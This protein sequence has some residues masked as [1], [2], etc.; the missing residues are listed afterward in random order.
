M[1]NC[2]D[3]DDPNSFWTDLAAFHVPEAIRTLV[4]VRSIEGE[5]FVQEMNEAEG[6]V[7]NA[8]LYSVNFGNTLSISGMEVTPQEFFNHIRLNFL[9]FDDDC[10]TTFGL[11]TGTSNER[12]LERWNSTDPVGSIVDIDI[13]A[14]G[15]IGIIPFIPQPDDATVV[16]S[17]FNNDPTQHTYNWTFSTISTPFSDNGDHPVSGHRQFG[18]VLNPDTGKWEFFIRGLDRVTSNILPSVVLD[19]GNT[20]WECLTNNLAKDLGGVVNQPEGMLT[21]VLWTKSP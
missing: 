20:L 13:H 5:W 14:A 8:D 4:E 18:L 17:D 12:D 3:P 19:G 11:N 9:D 2:F 7:V 15:R 1:R 10:N 16:T 21:Q 6:A